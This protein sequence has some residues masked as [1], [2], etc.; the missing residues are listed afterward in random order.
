MSE[1]LQ[2]VIERVDLLSDE[3]QMHLLAYLAERARQIVG[4]PRAKWLDLLGLAPN[5]LEGED[6]QAWISRTRR[7][8]TE[9][10]EATLQ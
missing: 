3:E 1:S 9:H 2:E 5:L 6:A 7:E 10:R 4:R 8:D